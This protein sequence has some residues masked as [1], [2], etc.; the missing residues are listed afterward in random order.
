MEDAI[1]VSFLMIRSTGSESITGPT[2]EFTKETGGTANK[3][4]MVPTLITRGLPNKEFGGK[5]KER[6]GKAKLYYTK[7][8]G[9]EF[10]SRKE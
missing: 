4:E 9:K 10:L 6:I 1:M 3:M 5:E 7:F 8:F 2:N